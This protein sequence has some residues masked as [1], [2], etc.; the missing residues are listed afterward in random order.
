MKRNDKPVRSSL[1]TRSWEALAVL[2]GYA[3]TMV[4]TLSGKLLRQR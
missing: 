4:E 1:L 2:V 3:P